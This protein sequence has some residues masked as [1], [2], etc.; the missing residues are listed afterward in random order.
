MKKK[1]PDPLRAY[2][3][4]MAKED[5]QAAVLD[6]G[7]RRGVKN[8]FIRFMRDEAI[9]DAL[10]D[11][12]RP[13]WVLDFGCG[14]GSLARFLAVRGMHVVGVDLTH[15]LLRYAQQHKISNTFFVQADGQ[16]L[17]FASETF[18]ACTSFW[19]LGYFHRP[20][21]LMA[22]LKEIHRILQPG[23]SFVAIEQVRS[24][25]TRVDCKVQRTPSQYREAFLQAGFQDL[26]CRAIR[27]GHSP[28]VYLFRYGLLGERSFQRMAAIE[29]AIGRRLPVPRFDYADYMFELRKL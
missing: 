8:A 17:P 18:A 21:A 23:G 11:L 2:W 10:C 13:S 19:V 15:G 25:D 6:P 22:A 4:V 3:E 24:R 29:R 16:K 5:P 14:S 9:W 27:R 12:P 26:H 28:I 20:T 1:H 7:D